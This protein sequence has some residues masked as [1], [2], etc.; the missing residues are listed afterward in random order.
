MRKRAES[1]QDQ[2]D[3]TSYQA[4]AEIGYTPQSRSNEMTVIGS[5]ARLEGNLISAGSLRIEGGVKG[6]ITA[7][8]DVIVANEAEV[9]ADIRA[10][11]VT[12]GGRYKGNVTAAGN[13]ELATTARVEGN[14]SCGSLIVNQGAVFSGQSIM[15][16]GA[17]ASELM[18]Q[19]P[20]AEQEPPSTQDE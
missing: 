12:I 14:I 11:N 13:L 4:E 5:G 16:G 7:E 9:E 6:H 2:T 19:T 3:M 1:E 10:N 8:G 15:G 17:N 20:R 18:Q